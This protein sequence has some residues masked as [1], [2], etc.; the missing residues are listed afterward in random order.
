MPARL[1][2][3][4][5]LA[6]LTVMLPACS[7]APA[8]KSV[9]MGEVEGLDV[10]KRELQTA[11]YNFAVHFAGQVE[12]ASTE[13]YSS[14]Q[15]ARIRRAA[16]EWNLNAIPE[17]MKACFSHDP[18]AG[19]LSSWA[20][21]I[22]MRE[23]LE[24]GNGREAFGPYQET[25]IKAAEKIEEDISRLAHAVWPEGDI[26]EYEQ[27]VAGFAAANPL[28]N[29]RFVREGFEREVLEAMGAGVA[30]GLGAVGA[31]N[32][33]MVALTD[34]ANL[35][36]PL[37]QRQ[38][39]WHTAMIKEDSREFVAE[40]ADSMV[41]ALGNEMFGHL[42]PLFEFIDQQRALIAGDVAR[43]RTAIFGSIAQE[44]SEVLNALAAEREEILTAIDNE[45]IATMR[46]V[47]TLILSVLET[48]RQEAQTGATSSVDHFYTRALQ[49]LAIPF[50]LVAIFIVVV[51][52]WVRNTVN[53]V[54]Q[55]IENG[56]PAPR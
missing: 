50:L 19:M 2:T 10:T 51:M 48:V 7:T 42:D 24:H 1:I 26:D 33:Q 31:M 43:E 21:A 47:E 34:R 45:R 29:M 37:L 53:R 16:I 12:L 23:F 27:R 36:V 15:D 3:L 54:L 55:R 4:S 35:M 9:F 49:V 39:Y 25:A 41:A 8:D 32:E 11:L 17:M 56:A 6:M 40:M 22:Q 44:R 13:I 38:I 20:F 52:V 30:G 28:K 14:T 46:D 18:L 5:V